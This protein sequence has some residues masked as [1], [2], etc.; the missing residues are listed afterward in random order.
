MKLKTLLTQIIKEEVSRQY[1]MKLVTFNVN[2]TSSIDVKQY[3]IDNIKD[4]IIIF[5]HVWY[6][7]D[8]IINIKILI[9][10]KRTLI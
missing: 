1:I 9:N 6:F 5:L 10:K 2:G 3:F 7:F 4:K 8:I